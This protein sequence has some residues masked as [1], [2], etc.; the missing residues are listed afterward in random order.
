MNEQQP[1]YYSKLF[2]DTSWS[3]NDRLVLHNRIGDASG[4]V[5][6]IV[7]PEWEVRLKI[8]TKNNR[9]FKSLQ[10]MMTADIEA[11]YDVVFENPIVTYIGGY[12][13]SMTATFRGGS[14]LAI[15]VDGDKGVWDTDGTTFDRE[16]K[17]RNARQPPF[18]LKDNPYPI[19]DLKIYF[20]NG[21]FLSFTAPY[22]DY[23]TTAAKNYN[24]SQANADIQ[25][26]FE[27]ARK[28]PNEQ[29]VVPTIG[30]VVAED[31]VTVE[32][33]VEEREYY[34]TVNVRNGVDVNGDTWDVIL[35]LKTSDD[36]W[37]IFLDGNVV[38]G[39]YDDAE[40]YDEAVAE[41][42]LIADA[43]AK[44][45]ETENEDD[46]DKPDWTNI[47]LGAGAGVL[48]IGIIAL[49]ILVLAVKK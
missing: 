31:T 3:D 6:L 20:G 47:I 19:P 21:M 30:D 43:R 16:A 4:R 26:V 39:N 1:F 45:A 14:M 8:R 49:T 27:W 46:V 5:Y 29:S 18:V 2:G 44:Q 7:K 35:R 15:T 33:Y 12:D 40:S 48:V 11:S 10:D 38:G 9:Y 17:S 37:Y 23:N 13:S 42:R 22:G 34:R 41:A 32:P 28:A 36:R 25:V 24:L